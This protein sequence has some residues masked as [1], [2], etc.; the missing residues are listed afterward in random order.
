MYGKPMARR[1]DERERLRA[2][3][4]GGDDVAPLPMRRRTRPNRAE[5]CRLCAV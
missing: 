2:L 1:P 4:G 5:A 3:F